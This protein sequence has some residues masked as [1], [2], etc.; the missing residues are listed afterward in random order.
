MDGPALSR[1]AQAKTRWPRTRCLAIKE[2]QNYEKFLIFLAFLGIVNH[3]KRY[4]I[5]HLLLYVSFLSVWGSYIDNSSQ[6]PEK[7]HPAPISPYSS[8]PLDG[9]WVAQELCLSETMGLTGLT[10]NI[11]MFEEEKYGKIINQRTWRHPKV[12]LK[13]KSGFKASHAGRSTV[14]DILSIRGTIATLLHQKL[15]CLAEMYFYGFRWLLLLV[16]FPVASFCIPQIFMLAPETK[17]KYYRQL[18]TLISCHNPMI[19]GSSRLTASA[20]SWVDSASVPQPETRPA[21][22]EKS[23]YIMYA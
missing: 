15:S 5:Y 14:N 1:Q 6:H 16:L 20:G 3:L 9:H 2:G 13:A 8:G 17:K 22:W 7:N 19:L 4:K 10:L 12:P 11:L 21:G 18:R 23:Y